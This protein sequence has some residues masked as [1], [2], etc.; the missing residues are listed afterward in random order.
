[1]TYRNHY[2]G[3]LQLTHLVEEYFTPNGA[4][5]AGNSAHSGLNNECNIVISVLCNSL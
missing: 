3:K 1:M 2:A 5:Q 4:N